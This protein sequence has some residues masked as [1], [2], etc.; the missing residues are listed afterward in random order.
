MLLVASKSP[1]ITRRTSRT[2]VLVTSSIRPVRVQKI[3]TQEENGKA[4]R[5]M[6]PTILLMD[7]IL[8]RFSTTAHPSLTLNS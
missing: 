4:K 1:S 2:M 6:T 7:E 5:T 8:N 3:Q